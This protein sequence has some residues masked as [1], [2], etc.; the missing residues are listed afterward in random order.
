MKVLVLG[1][2]NRLFG[3]DGIGP[4]VIQAL[5]DISLPAGVKVVEAWGSFYHYWDILLESRRVIVVDSMFGGGPPGTIYRVG[6]D[7]FEWQKSE[8]IP[9]EIP[10][11]SVLKMASFY[12]AAP[13]VTIIG[14]E[15]KQLNCSLELSPE[16]AAKLP[17]LTSMVRECFLLKR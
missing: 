15:P 11:P 5:Q 17:V 2:G 6:L 12:G 8:G 14:V 1:L 9:H 16:V 13:E 10:F 7:S 4:R 3:D